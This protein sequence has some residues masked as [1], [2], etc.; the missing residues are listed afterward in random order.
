MVLYVHR[1]HTYGLLGTWEEWDR[2][3][4]PG[5]LPVHTAPVF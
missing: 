4:D 2:E 5:H 3:R 1:N